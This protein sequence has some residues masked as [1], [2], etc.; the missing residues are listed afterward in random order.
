MHKDPAMCTRILPRSSQCAEGSGSDW[1]STLELHLPKARLYPDKHQHVKDQPSAIC[2]PPACQGS[3][4]CHMP[5]LVFITSHRQPQDTLSRHES[6]GL[7]TIL[8]A[9]RRRR[10]RRHISKFS[11]KFTNSIIYSQPVTFPHCY[12]IVS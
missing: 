2:P 10:R 8:K 4:I 9:R 11:L 5:P 12:Q 6:S 7:T 1:F 3:A